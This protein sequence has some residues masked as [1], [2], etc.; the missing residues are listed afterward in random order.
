MWPRPWLGPAVTKLKVAYKFSTLAAVIS[1]PTVRR[2]WRWPRSTTTQHGVSPDAA[3]EPCGAIGSH[4]VLAAAETI[5]SQAEHMGE[6]TWCPT[7]VG[8]DRE[9]EGCRRGNQR[10]SERRALLLSTGAVVEDLQPSATA[11]VK[12]A[13]PWADGRV[14]TPAGGHQDRVTV[15]VIG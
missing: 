12:S 6:C 8:Q 7:V 1:V 14:V 5:G 13:A 3:R 15:G 11:W 9:N 4:D 2:I 10:R